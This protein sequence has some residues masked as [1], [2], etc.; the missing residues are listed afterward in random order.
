MNFNIT[1]WKRTAGGWS[2]FELRLICKLVCGVKVTKLFWKVTKR[3]QYETCWMWLN[4][5]LNITACYYRFRFIIRLWSYFIPAN[6]HKLI[7]FEVLFRTFKADFIAF[8]WR[9]SR[10]ELSLSLQMWRRQMEGGGELEESRDLSA[11]GQQQWPLLLHP[12]QPVF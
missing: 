8:L 1:V 9:F 10:D 12:Q 5:Q 2:L 3:F 6:L 7:R 4:F 11:G